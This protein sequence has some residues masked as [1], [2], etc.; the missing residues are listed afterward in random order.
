MA[1]NNMPICPECKG[2]R[3]EWKSVQVEKPHTPL[4]YFVACYFCE[5]TGY[6]SDEDDF[7]RF[8]D[9]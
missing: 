4:S 2:A 5:G 9:Q 8:W 6:A 3:G 7:E 1:N